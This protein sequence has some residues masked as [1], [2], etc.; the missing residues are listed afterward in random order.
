[1]KRI[2]YLIVLAIPLSAVVF[3]FLPAIALGLLL[4]AAIFNVEY[5]RLNIIRTE[6]DLSTRRSRVERPAS[7]LLVLERAQGCAKILELSTFIFFGSSHALRSKVQALLSDEP[8][9]RWLVLDF[10]NVPGFDVST[11]QILQR[12]QDDCDTANV[13]LV[14]S[15]LSQSHITALHPVDPE[16]QVGRTLDACLAEIEDVVISEAARESVLEDEPASDLALFLQGPRVQAMAKTSVYQKGDVVIAEASQ[17]RDIYVLLSGRLQAIAGDG[18]ANRVVLATFLPGVVVG[19][20]AYYTGGKRSAAIVAED[21]SELVHLDS[22]QIDTLE[23]SDPM[24]AAQFHRL[25]A[26]NLALRLGR[27]NRQ[28]LALDG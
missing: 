18:A 7:D 15:G 16:A 14:L 4:C 12:I 22:A 11:Q 28:L 13:T 1:L 23:Q 21:R 24:L 20:M 19:E 17:S 10:R 3:G 25:I 27:S 6:S 9:L 8:S 26:R 5:S 2:D